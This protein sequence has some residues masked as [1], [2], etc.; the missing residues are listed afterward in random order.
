[1]GDLCQVLMWIGRCKYVQSHYI[2]VYETG[3]KMYSICTNFEGHKE[4][5][6]CFRAGQ[7]VD[8]LML[9]YESQTGYMKILETT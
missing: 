6:E 4:A 1:M 5:A 7:T 2:H 9:S 3:I 8:A